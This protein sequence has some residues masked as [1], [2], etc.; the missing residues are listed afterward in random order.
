MWLPESLFGV[1]LTEDANGRIVAALG[2]ASDD[3]ADGGLFLASN[4]RLLLG[5][6]HVPHDVE[7]GRI[8]FAA[9]QVLGGGDVGRFDRL[10]DDVHQ[11]FGRLT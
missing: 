6:F 1:E 9:T 2:S 5:R 8:H 4:Q 10:D 11:I 7:E 3:G